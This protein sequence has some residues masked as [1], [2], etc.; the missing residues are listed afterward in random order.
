MQDGL[1]LRDVHRP[2]APSPWPPAPGWW[3]VA[4]VLLAIVA[5]TAFVRG[6]RRRRRA[7]AVA[8]F[9]R[10]LDGASRPSTPSARLAAASELLRRAARVQ[11][12]DADRLQGDAWLDFL[13]TPRT[14]FV[15]GPGRLLL[16][17]PFRAD[18]SGDESDA[19]L[20]LARA[21]FIELMERRR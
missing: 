2:P 17:G 5:G 9:D 16:D 6:R 8:M 18:V 14:R 7:A 13:D 12:A 21:R 15:D 10:K 3:A 4:F 11:C 1:I 20:R 19:A